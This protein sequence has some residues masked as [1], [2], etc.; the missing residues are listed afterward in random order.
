MLQ[1]RKHIGTKENVIVGA[2]PC[3]TRKSDEPLQTMGDRWGG[4][5][6]KHLGLGQGYPDVTL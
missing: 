3:R 1:S 6:I 4:V 5:E 2:E